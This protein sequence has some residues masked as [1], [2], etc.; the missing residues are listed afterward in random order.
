MASSATPPAPHTVACCCAGMAWYVSHN[1]VFIHQSCAVRYDYYDYQ[2][3]LAML[4]TN[5]LQNISPGLAC[6]TH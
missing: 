2:E 4:L 5:L 3:L 6:G 1:L